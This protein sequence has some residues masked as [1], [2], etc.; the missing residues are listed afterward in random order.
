M[1]MLP[2]TTERLGG[3]AFTSFLTAGFAAC[4]GMSGSVTLSGLTHSVT[5]LVVLVITVA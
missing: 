3:T 5:I 4:W 1:S 2:L